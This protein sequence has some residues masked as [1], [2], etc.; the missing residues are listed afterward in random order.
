MCESVAAT[1]PA[2][3]PGPTGP[4]RILSHSFCTLSRKG[5]VA[6]ARRGGVH[7]A[8]ALQIH[9]V[10]L[11]KR[12][13]PTLPSVPSCACR[14]GCLPDTPAEVVMFQEMPNL[15]VLYQEKK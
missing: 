4:I 2:V 14:H 13:L 10:F 9:V 8:V 5:L 7:P 15:K 12:P 3:R 6:A 1:A 11:P